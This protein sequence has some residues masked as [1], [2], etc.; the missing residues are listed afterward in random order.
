MAALAGLTVIEVR[1]AETVRKTVAVPVMLPEVPVAVMG[2]MPEGGDEPTVIVMVE[3]PDPTID[4]G[5]KLTVTPFGW[6]VADKTM[7][8]SK[9]PVGV[10]V[11]TEVPE[12]PFIT[13]TEP[14][15]A[16]R[17]KPREG[18]SPASAAGCILD[19]SGSG[20]ACLSSRA[21]LARPGSRV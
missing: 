2:Y 17:M 12:L 10:L 14:G 21:L 7:A 19:S 1:V 18:G 20:A 11:M 3:V 15:E 8:E 5:L 6:P 9:P 16:D 4:V 13:P